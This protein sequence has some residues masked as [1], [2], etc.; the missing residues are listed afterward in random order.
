MNF[1]GFYW[2][3]SRF[4]PF[5]NDFPCFLLDV[6]PFF[7]DFPWFLLDFEP[8][9]A[10]FP[11]LE[12]QS[13]LAFSA[14]PKSVVRVHGPSQR[15]PER[16]SEFA[17]L[18]R[19]FQEFPAEFPRSLPGSFQGC[20]RSHGPSQGLKN[21]SGFPRV[22]SGLSGCVGLLKPAPHSSQ[23]AFKATWNFQVFLIL[24]RLSQF[25]GVLSKF[26]GPL[27]GSQNG[28]QSSQIFLVAS[29]NFPRSSHGPSLGF[30]PGCQGA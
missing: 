22:L 28:G 15:P 13:S 14:A 2:I 21:F 10:V 30:F 12:R 18:L 17:G 16:L 7:N 24:P 25:P 26:A 4:Q 5:F 3:L 8:F 27:K 9:V 20:Q 11:L 23:G 29:R 6:E 1:F 19:G